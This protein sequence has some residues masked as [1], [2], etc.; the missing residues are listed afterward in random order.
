MK[1][2]RN[3]TDCFINNTKKLKLANLSLCLE[4]G[5]FEGKTTNYIV[6]N[7]LSD[8]GEIICVDPLEDTYL[9]DNLNADDELNNKHWNC[10]HNQYD[11]F[12]ENTKLNFKK[13]KL[14]RELSSVALPKLALEYK[15]KFDFVY[16]DGDHREGGVY[17]DGLM[18]LELCKTGG[19]ILFDDYLWKDCIGIQTAKKGIDR[20]LSENTYNIQIV[21]SNYQLAIKKIR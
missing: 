1:Y 6:D 14:H 12:I 16:V 20:L 21:I 9:V 13:I 4:I 10:F 8:S 17:S 5:C 11:R 2:T 19:I 3:W 15:N 18:S 7:M